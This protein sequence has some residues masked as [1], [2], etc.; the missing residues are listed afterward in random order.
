MKQKEVR[1]G[2]FNGGTPRPDT[3]ETNVDIAYKQIDAGRDF[4][5][6]MSIYAEEILPTEEEVVLALR[7][8]DPAQYLYRVC[9]HRALKYVRGGFNTGGYGEW[10][11][12][13]ASTK[14]R[15]G[16]DTILVD[17]ARLLADITGKITQAKQ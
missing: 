7:D 8:N 4:L 1:I 13:A 17:E 2:I 9:M 3:E 11:D 16:H 10:R 15:K 6:S 14:K 12:I 5:I